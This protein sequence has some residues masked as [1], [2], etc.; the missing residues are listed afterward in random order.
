[1]VARRGTKDNIEAGPKLYRKPTVGMGPSFGC[2][3]GFVRRTIALLRLKTALQ[4]G[5]GAETDARSRV[6]IEASLRPPIRPM[7][8][9]EG[10][11]TIRVVW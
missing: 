7:N 9:R 1:M 2:S 5:V 11:I 3:L 4:Q 10:T 6:S 8:R